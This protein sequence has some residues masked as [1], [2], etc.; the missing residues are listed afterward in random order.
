M[1]SEKEL[2]ENLKILVQTLT[3][4][5]TDVTAFNSDTSATSHQQSVNVQLFHIE[6]EILEHSV[7]KLLRKCS[8]I[9]KQT[10]ST[11]ELR[12]MITVTLGSILALKQKLNLKMVQL[13]QEEERIA[14]VG[15]AENFFEKIRNRLLAFEVSV[16]LIFHRFGM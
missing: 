1:K 11:E 2:K 4:F 13:I 7:R 9:D 12:T 14:S 15:E 10:S 6:A 16:N 8:K 3:Q 5:Q